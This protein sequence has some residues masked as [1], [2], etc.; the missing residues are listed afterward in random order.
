[1][2]S[3]LDC[4]PASA[5]EVLAAH[6]NVFDVWPMASDVETHL[7][8]R[9]DAPK[10][11]RANYFVGTVDGVVAAS[12]QSFPTQFQIRGELVRGIQIGSVHTHADYRKKGYA[13]LLIDFTEKYEAEQGVQLSVLY[14]DIAVQYYAKMGYQIAPSRTGWFITKDWSE[15]RLSSA[16]ELEVIDPRLELQA[17]MALHQP[18]V[19]KRPIGVVRD[20]A[21][22]DYTFRKFPNDEFWVMRN[23]EAELT[24][25]V[26]VAISDGIAQ[27]VDWICLEDQPELIQS[28]LLGMAKLAKTRGLEKIGGW[29][30]DCP[31]VRELVELVDRP[32]QLTMFKP[33]DQSL[34]LD[35]EILE[36]ANYFT[37]IDHV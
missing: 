18:T 30:P 16:P 10:S 31:V 15:E 1:M 6:R 26:R 3:Q 36:T 7:A 35:P 14:C 20:E 23:S 22:W 27:I 12:L 29:L 37:L 5:E 21:Y 24:G 34:E 32:K 25:F 2:S 9:K 8:K 11:L 28:L 4:H 13:E 33:L 17:L 19:F